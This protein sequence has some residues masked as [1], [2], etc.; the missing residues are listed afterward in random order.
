MVRA[1]REPALTSRWFFRLAVIGALTLPLA[2][3]ACGR[4]GPLDPPPRA[5]AQPA[6]APQSG[7]QQQQQQQPQWGLFGDAASAEEQQGLPPEPK[8]QKK[9]FL[10]DWLLN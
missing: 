5:S 3:S 1:I 4:K 2:L 8:G 6:E 10:L 9:G 7:Q